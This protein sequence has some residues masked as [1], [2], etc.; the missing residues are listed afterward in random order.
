MKKRN[1]KK[2]IISALE[3][4]ILFDGAA[5]ATAVDVLDESSFSKSSKDAVS[6]NDVTKN[7]AENSV[8][9]AQAVK[10][11]EKN[12]KEV[13]FVD[14]TVKDYQ[15][16][17]DEIGEGVET[18]LVSSMNDIK[19]I[20]SNEVNIDSIHILS[21]GNIGEITVG[22]D[23]LNKNTLSN[24]DSVL[25]NM[26]SS[27]SENGDILLYGCN[28]AND[29]NGEAFINLFANLTDAD[30]AASNDITG[31]SS[32]NGDW[33]LEYKFGT[34]ETQNLVLEKYENSLANSTPFILG[35]EKAS[36][37]EDGSLT[38]NG[39]KVSDKDTTDELTVK[40]ISQHGKLDLTTR[41]GVTVS[42]D[43]TNTLIIK[44]TNQAQ[45]NDALNTL[46]YT[47]DA[48]YSGTDAL[49]ITVADNQG[50]GERGYRI[51]ETGKF[52]NTLNEHYYEYISGSITWDAAKTAAEAKTLYGLKGYL[53]TITSVEENALITSMAGGNGWIG[54]SDSA[55][56]GIWKWVTGPEAGI[57][58]WTGDTGAGTSSTTKY[59]SAYNSGYANWQSGEP[60]N[61]DSSRGGED[62]AHFYSNNGEWNDYASANTNS[63]T[64]Y[65]V[66]YGGLSGDNLQTA[67]LTITINPVNDA[68]TIEATT[69]VN[70]TENS[71]GIPLSPFLTLNDIDNTT[72]ANATVSIGGFVAGDRLNFISNSS[73]MGNITVS[74]NVNG[75]LTLTSSDKSATLEQWQTALRSVTYDSTSEALSLTNTPRTVSWS[76]SDGSLTST[77]DTSTINVVGVNDAPII[78]VSDTVNYTENG[79]AIVLL[80]NNNITLNDVDNTTLASATVSIGGFV[81]G[82]RLNF[83]SNS[84]TMGNISGSY[85]STTGIFT[86][87]S[88]DKS[89]TLEQWQNALK[90]ITYDSTSEALSL[91][92]QTRNVSWVV[93][94]GLLNS[95]VAT[96]TI[97]VTGINDAPTLTVSD[98]KN[99]LTESLDTNKQNLSKSGTISF[100]DVDNNVTISLT[101]SSVVWSGGTLDGS[102]ATALLNGF[103][104]SITNNTQTGSGT[105]S[106]NVNNIDLNFLA[107]NET[108]TFSYTIKAT[109]TSGVTHTKTVT[110]KIIGT[111]DAPTFG[112]QDPANANSINSTVKPIFENA[113]FENGLTG[114]TTNGKATIV[115]K[116]TVTFSASSSMQMTPEV[117]AIL[118]NSNQMTWV[119]DSHGTGMI[120]LEANGASNEFNTNFQSDLNVSSDTVKYIK[121][122]FYVTSN[123]VPT[124]MAYISKTFY[125]EAGTTYSIAWNYISGDYVPWN[126]GSVLTFA[127]N[128]NPSSTAV[129]DGVKAEV[130]LL[131]ATN[132]GTGNYTTS[133]YGSTGWQTTTIQVLESGTYTLGLSVFNL[134]DTALNP[135]L[136]VDDIVGTTTLNNQIFTPLNPDINAPV[137]AGETFI[138]ET[139]LIETNS[140]LSSSGTMSIEDKDL[141]DSV[142]VSVKS[143]S[144]DLRD[145][146][147]NLISNSLSQTTNEQ[148]LS[149]LSLDSTLIIESGNTKGSFEWYFNSGSEAFNYLKAGEVLKLTYTFQAD[150][151][152]GGVTEQSIDVII[153]GTNDAVV[154]NPLI[155]I[156]IVNTSNS[157]ESFSKVTGAID[158]TDLDNDNLI[159]NILNSSNNPVQELVGIYGILK[160]NSTTGQYEY[161]PNN[162]KINALTNT[163]TESFK[164][165]VSDSSTSSIQNLAVKID[166]VNKMPLIGGGKS[167]V[168]FVENSKPIVIDSSITIV[169]PEYADFGTGYLRVDYL[170]GK[171]GNDNLT[172][173]ELGGIT[174]DRGD[175]LY[176]GVKIGTID[177]LQNGENGKSL[178]INLNDKA[179]SHQVQ[180][181]A[182]A[183]AFVNSTDNLSDNLRVIEFRVNDGGDSDNSMRFSSKE[184][185]INIQTINDL[186][187]INFNN[188]SYVV[189]KIINVNEDGTLVLDKISFADLDGEVLTVVLETTNYGTLTIDELFP[190]GLISSQIVG[191]GTNKVILNGTIAEINKTLASANG[192]TYK[193][194]A[195]KDFVTPGADF[196][197]ITATDELSG[198]SVSSKM[199]IV[200]PAIPNADSKNI[201]NK[202]DNPVTINLENLILDINDNNGFFTIG[203]GKADITDVNG[204]ITTPGNISSFDITDIIYDNNSKAIGYQLTSG[205]LILADDSSSLENNFM[206]K[207]GQFIFIPNE[208]W[209]GSETFVYQYKSG[210]G[211]QSFI[212]QINIF[213]LPVNDK[214]VI[215]VTT[216]DINIDED[217]TYTFDNSNLIV[218]SDIDNISTQEVELQIEVTEGRVN[219][220]ELS[221]VTILEGE[222]G[223]SKILLRGTLDNLKEAIKNL[224]Y[225][226]KNN[227]FGNDYLTIVLDD[228]GNSGE[229]GNKIFNQTINFTIKSVN[230]K[231]QIEVVDVE[232]LIEDG[233]KLSDTG[234]IKFSDADITDRPTAVENTK[235]I[236][237][238]AQDGTNL[239]L[240]QKQISDIENAF[241]INNLPTNVNNG[242]ITWEYT[243]A[244]DKIDF[245]GKDETVTAVFTITVIDDE[246]EKVTKDVTVTITGTN[247]KPTVSFENIDFEIPFGEVY[248]KDISSLFSDKD[249]TNKFRFEATNLPLGLT[250]DSNTG[251]ISGR[252]S[253]AGNFVISIKGIDSTGD[254]VT[255][256]YNILVIAPAKIV[257]PTKSNL[258]SIPVN[259]DIN[260]NNSTDSLNNFTTTNLNNIGVLNFNS[261]NGLSVDPGVGFLDIL[262]NSSKNDRELNSST[263]QNR[264]VGDSNNYSSTNTLNTNDSRGL[265]QANV[266][267][268]VLI[269]GQVVFNE[270]NQ[271]SFSIVGITIEEIKLENNYIEIKVVDINLSQNFIVTQI[272]GSP[273]PTG[274]SFD[275][276]TGNITGTIPE[277]LE[278]LEIS[279]KAINLDGTTKVLNLKLNLNDLKNKTKVQA[280]TNEK[281]IGLKEQIALENKKFEGYGEYLTKLFA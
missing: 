270:A 24:F 135:Y 73:T 223:S 218:I 138:V 107:K 150:D 36:V 85:N 179:Y 165:K 177:T 143:V 49:K 5:I 147:N 201:I 144:V 278:K 3:Q 268:N 142:T 160:L 26:K 240:T 111:N 41:T 174:V 237:A 182:R 148:L 6:Q 141:K 267:L 269:N 27:L 102:I 80:P 29:G 189:E 219:L 1:L 28:V 82:D 264:E 18:Y 168:I 216:N 25:Q 167:E 81:A 228:L 98:L 60:N 212:A 123:K 236:T 84:S 54:A 248:S 260:I 131:G 108:I 39:F 199:V 235:S 205:K 152:N 127:N 163:V 217:T 200:L 161:I 48:N 58:F 12:K 170:Q 198:T 181:L 203:L 115:D 266:D 215:N 56:E 251:I 15:T 51:S 89:A 72:L 65:I 190:N 183:I 71:S 79:S 100:N 14:V 211:E 22:N 195:G 106:Y 92:T 88:S 44:G 132:P 116:D 103:S 43:N 76:I 276:R 229:G 63:I 129:L 169:D 52:F 153:T 225:T 35:K 196:I 122:T 238:K 83:T 140:G 75:I 95:T 246:G 59:G 118:G 145:S 162:T 7:N 77:L 242:T 188:S 279:I 46:K 93:N 166:Y 66:E 185:I 87:I 99:N 245:L 42:G 253:Q 226:P 13:A 9:E 134:G 197:K 130:I 45:L 64:G 55:S 194:G 53:V 113:G 210:D 4:R 10:S 252:V 265:L 2:P 192:L 262:N 273:L 280:D 234:S 250:I 114:W 213:V 128:T 271:N 68:P 259:D 244:Q 91:T 231:P 125:A 191:N 176:S 263:N 133:S 57:Q 220:E 233:S 224:I 275:P 78:T 69:T 101:P 180:A 50:S 110:F 221:K 214:P 104:T 30:V 241:L 32:L 258:P 204:N 158:T 8:H 19:L 202:E 255:R 243:I 193:S 151:G 20:L 90:S 257:E 187:Q 173:L 38:I 274:M 227:Y 178:K 172:I 117:K 232:G 222:N 256:T 157:L 61:S 120:K 67:N 164:I 31:N 37:N 139:G 11:F 230:D 119:V 109:D 261:N 33:N 209:Y 186:P 34:I 105:W 97:E 17:V 171:E 112:A 121:D 272:D 62:V 208:N 124:N 21:H 146:S 96:S 154:V 136:F 206:S 47:P 70:Y 86:L 40:I 254:S 156:E 207:N 159:Y 74:S 23:I 175:V 137:P 94:D 184:S 249:L 16:L 281:Y 239:P 247:D 277:D 155:P 126:D 149:M